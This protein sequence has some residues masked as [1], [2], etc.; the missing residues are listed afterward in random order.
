MA[1][2]EYCP[3]FSG[4][5]DEDIEEF[6]V[7][8]E[9]WLAMKKVV[10]DNDRME[11]IGPCLRGAARDYYMFE[12]AALG[13]YNDRKDRLIAKYASTDRQRYYEQAL[14]QM[15]M[16]DAESP[17]DFY[18]RLTIVAKRAHPGRLDDDR[19]K[20]NEM[21]KPVFRQGLPT[22][23]RAHIALVEDLSDQVD[24][25]QKVWMAMNNP[26]ITTTDDPLVPRRS[27]HGETFLPR[28]THKVLQPGAVSTKP[29]QE[30]GVVVE[31]K[32][33][34]LAD[35]VSKLTLLVQ[36]QQQQQERRSTNRHSDFR[37]QRNWQT[38]PQRRPNESTWANR[39]ACYNCGAPDHFARNCPKPV[40]SQ[41]HKEVRDLPQQDNR[42]AS[43]M[44]L[45]L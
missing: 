28:V 24:R 14:H 11:Y 9:A 42:Y 30:D 35:Q 23:L 12:V 29:I 15:I 7:Q 44:P 27:V 6:F 8:L 22:E 31:S 13:S 33:A 34:E 26:S 5:H 32:L 19:T 3:T 36:Q 10:G 43:Q 1:K 37:P 41:Q 2:I 16:G 20:R 17:F 39:K 40:N 4:Y 45:N 25:A 18:S 38:Q 21:I